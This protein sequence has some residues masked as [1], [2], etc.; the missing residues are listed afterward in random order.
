[1][2]GN[3][4]LS[5]LDQCEACT[6]RARVSQ[7]KST[8]PSLSV[9]C[10]EKW[11]CTTFCR[12]CRLLHRPACSTDKATSVYVAVSMN[13]PGVDGPAGR[14]GSTAQTTGPPACEPTN[15]Q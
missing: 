5:T 7:A 11:V 8:R 9:S 10:S 6:A 4:W 1:M 3:K 12:D 15:E 14:I 13:S 2:A